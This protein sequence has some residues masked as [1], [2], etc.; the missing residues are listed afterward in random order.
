MGNV[1]DKSCKEFEAHN[2][3]S[4]TL[5]ENL[6]VYDNTPKKHCTARQSTDDNIIRGMHFA[7]YRHTLRIC[8][9]SRFPRQQWLRERATM[10]R[11][12]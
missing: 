5:L 12:T 10:L 4:I 2:L 3:W 7:C 1:S 6:V 9:T 11:Y 8:N